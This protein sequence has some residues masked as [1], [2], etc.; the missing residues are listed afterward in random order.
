MKMAV[1]SV[2]D[3]RRECKR[4]TLLALNVNLGFWGKESSLPSVFILRAQCVEFASTRQRLDEMSGVLFYCRVLPNI[5]GNS[6]G[7][8]QKACLFTTTCGFKRLTNGSMT[9]Q[10]QETNGSLGD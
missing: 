8:E 1:V 4:K 2:N 3:N 7:L 9:K 5:S 6:D 10:S